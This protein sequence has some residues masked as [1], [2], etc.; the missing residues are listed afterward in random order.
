MV[1]FAAG[2][3]SL[4]FREEGIRMTRQWKAFCGID[5]KRR[6]HEISDEASVWIVGTLIIIAGFALM[7]NLVELP[8]WR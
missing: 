7:F 5:R 8:G 4:V 3:L 1:L 6:P 2:S